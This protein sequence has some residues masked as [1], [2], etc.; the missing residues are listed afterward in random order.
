MKRVLISFSLQILLAFGSSAEAQ[1]VLE[2]PDAALGLTVFAPGKVMSVDVEKARFNLGHVRFR[3][4]PVLYQALN[5]SQKAAAMRIDIL[6]LPRAFNNADLVVTIDG[7]P[8]TIRLIWTVDNDTTFRDSALSSKLQLL[9]TT[10]SFRRIAAA[11]D[12]YLTVLLPGWAPDRYTVHLV[13]ENLDVF[14][15]MLSKYDDLEPHAG[16][17]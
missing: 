1:E 3:V 8:A 5:K 6:G 11:K 2:K 4:Y 15:T 16:K 12:V 10:G 7:Q 14:K 9:D 17:Q 13:G